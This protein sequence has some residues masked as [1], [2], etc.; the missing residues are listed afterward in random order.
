MTD[1]T[2]HILAGVIVGAGIWALSLVSLPI[3]I[4]LSGAAMGIGYEVSQLIRGDGE[5]DGMDALATL[6]GAALVAGFCWII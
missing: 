4:L 6:F 3:A 1:K 2:L 5:P